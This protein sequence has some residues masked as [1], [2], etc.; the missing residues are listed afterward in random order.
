MKQGDDTVTDEAADQRS[1]LLHDDGWHDEHLHSLAE[2]D[3]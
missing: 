2:G 3:I 1:A